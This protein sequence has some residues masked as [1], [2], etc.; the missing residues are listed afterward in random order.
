VILVAAACLVSAPASAAPA[1]DKQTQAQ[2]LA[3]QLEDQGRRI[4]ILDE[5]YNQARARA[6][7]LDAQLAALG[8]RLAESDRHLAVARERLGRTSVDAYVR[9]GSAPLL[10]ALIRARSDDL[11]VRRTYV[12]AALQGQRGALAGF[13]SA[14]RQLVRLRDELRTTQRSARATASALDA[15]RK[16]AE[17]TITSQQSARARAQGDMAP[18]VAEATAQQALKTQQQGKQRFDKLA[19]PP[20]PPPARHIGGSGNV[21]PTTTVKP[22]AGPGSGSATTTTTAHPSSPPTTAAPKPAAPTGPPPPVS[23]GAGAAVNTAKAQLGKP[24]VYGGAGPD[25]FDCS[26]LTMYAWRAGGVGLPHS[27]AMQYT[28]VPHVALTALQPGDLIFFGDPIYHMGIY[29]GGGQMIEAPH[30]GEVVRYASI[31]RPD[32]M[33]AGRP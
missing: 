29:V 1:P 10:G 16:A 9:G 30:T 3:Q 32:L 14:R 2:Q 31:Y 13:E 6:E 18:L 15:N 21:A 4:S 26:G 7:A 20:P 17:A 33:G 5:Q 22:A 19:A 11:G 25:N 12:D 27:A 8:P 24:Y 23:S 28:A